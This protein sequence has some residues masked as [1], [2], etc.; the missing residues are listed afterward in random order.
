MQRK[1]MKQELRQLFLTSRNF[2][3]RKT[4]FK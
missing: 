3:I 2:Q 4:L 1:L